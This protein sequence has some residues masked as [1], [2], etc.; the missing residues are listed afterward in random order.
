MNLLDFY[1]PEWFF[2]A[3]NLLIL[4]LVLRALLWKPVNRILDE[5]EER[6]EKAASDAKEATEM[7]AEMERLRQ[8]FD[9]DLETNTVEMMKDAR[10][11]AGHEYERIV[12]DAEKKAER[13]LAE[14]RAKAEREYSGVMAEAKKQIVA[15]ALDISGMLLSSSVD[16]EQNRAL[17]NNYLAE[18]EAF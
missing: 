8:Q 14:A 3:V 12:A 4:M 17:L 11:R 13:I 6:A 16:S 18:K 15:A 2:V 7:K 9:V 5:R 10:A 1:I